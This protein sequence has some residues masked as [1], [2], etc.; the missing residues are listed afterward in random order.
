MDMNYL[1]QRKINAKK[2]YRKKVMLTLVCSVIVLVLMIAGL[3][4]VIVD[5]KNAEDNM[6]MSQFQ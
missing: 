5:E 6:L 2:A 1:V 4:K 3:I